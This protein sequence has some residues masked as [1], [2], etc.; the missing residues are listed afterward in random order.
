MALGKILYKV[1][2]VSHWNGKINWC[3]V[4]EKGIK[5][6]II[7]CGGSE[8]G[9]IYQDKLFEDY[10]IQAKKHGLKVGAYFFGFGSDYQK[11]CN[12]ALGMREII[13]GKQFELP[14]FLDYES[15][16]NPGT[17][18]GN[19]DYCRGFLHTLDAF[20]YWVGMYGSDSS[21]FKSLVNRDELM[22]FTWWVAKYSSKEPTYATM[23][24]Q[25][26]QYSSTYDL[27]GHNTDIN[28]VYLDFE[29]II[30]RKGLNGY[31]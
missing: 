19:T 18:Q 22:D 29:P 23:N 8:T 31:D 1:I 27:N 14:V 12:D 7:K 11:G 16:N 26:W 3:S 25:I 30:K 10:Y 2:D 6:V 28:N 4:V 15:P 21:T 20:N 24:C 17:K 5:G 13:K 9:K